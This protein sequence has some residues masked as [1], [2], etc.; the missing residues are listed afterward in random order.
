MKRNTTGNDPVSQCLFH[1]WPQSRASA[2]LL[3]SYEK[4][5]SPRN[6]RRYRFEIFKSFWRIELADTQDSRFYLRRNIFWSNHLK[7]TLGDGFIVTPFKAGSLQGNLISITPDLIG[8]ENYTDTPT[9]WMLRLGSRFY[10]SK[11][12]PDVLLKI[13]KGFLQAWPHN[14]RKFIKELDEYKAWVDA[15][16]SLVDVE[17][18]LEHG[19]L[20]PNN[21]LQANGTLR[22][23]DFEFVKAYQVIGF[24]EYSNLRARKLSVD[25]FK[26]DLQLVFDYKWKLIQKINNLWENSC[27]ELL[28]HRKRDNSVTFMFGQPTNKTWKATG[29]S[30][31]DGRIM[32]SESEQLNLENLENHSAQIL[33]N[34]IIFDNLRVAFERIGSGSALTTCI[35]SFSISKMIS[36]SIN[37]KRIIRAL[38]RLISGKQLF[39]YK[40]ESSHPTDF[41]ITACG[42]FWDFLTDLSKK[43]AQRPMRMFCWPICLL[44]LH[45]RWRRCRKRGSGIKVSTSNYKD[46]SLE[47]QKCGIRHVL[48]RGSC[49]EFGR[50]DFDI[51]IDHEEIKQLLKISSKFS[52]PTPVDV[53]FDLRPSVSTYHYFPPQMALNILRS[54]E[55]SEEGLSVPAP[56]EHFL[57][58]AFHVLYH[59]GLNESLDN[60]LLDTITSGPHFQTLHTLAMHPEVLYQG[61]FSMLS[62]HNFLDDRDWSMPRDLI[63]RWPRQHTFLKILQDISLKKLQK[64]N[65]DPNYLV[66]LIREDSDASE[67]LTEIQKKIETKCQILSSRRLFKHETHRLQNRTRGGNWYEKFGAGFKLV[68]PSHVFICTNQSNM[69]TGQFC[70]NELVALKREIRAYVNKHFPLRDG[71]RFVL[72]AGDDVWDSF[73][74]FTLLDNA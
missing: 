70:A 4:G 9:E 10:Y 37:E 72:H 58:L 2:R 32:F 49:A 53:Y 1:V 14:L 29:V 45:L 12:S 67:I 13:E 27:L 28:I 3:N 50:S 59:K 16:K 11:I 60:P 19:D 55:L 40:I 57:S 39:G 30:Q 51:L 6:R 48:L 64:L 38:R 33:A 74:Y 52:G 66:F 35:L 63:G 68:A 7:N 44:R 5:K 23:I 41:N 8:A 17:L 34:R 71:K 21:I 62:L 22:L 36:K 25:G 42:N 31:R 20:A 73:E 54:S 24:D 43:Y 61:D 26:D 15:T 18:G 46:F 47:L 69:T 56:K 65:S